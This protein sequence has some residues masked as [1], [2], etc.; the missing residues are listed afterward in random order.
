MIWDRVI[1]D[2]AYGV[3]SKVVDAGVTKVVQFTG[4]AAI[5]KKFSHVKGRIEAGELLNIDSLRE[6]HV[7]GWL[8]SD[9]QRKDHAQWC[10]DIYKRAGGKGTATVV[11]NTASNAEQSK[12]TAS[13]ATS[14]SSRTKKMVEEETLSL[15]KK[16]KVSR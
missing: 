12:S 7:F 14:S 11:N 1:P 16:R 2:C 6:F 9:E 13:R 5:E 8:M 10:N 3:N 4:S 15:F